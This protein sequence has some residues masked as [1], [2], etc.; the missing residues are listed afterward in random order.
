M[1]LKQFRPRLNA[2][3]FCVSV[4]PFS[5]MIQHFIHTQNSHTFATR[6]SRVPLLVFLLLVPLRYPT[7]RSIRGSPTIH[8]TPLLKTRAGEGEEEEEEEGTPDGRFLWIY[9]I[10]KLVS[11]E[12][13]IDASHRRSHLR[14][15]RKNR[16]KGAPSFR[17][18]FL[19]KDERLAPDCSTY[20]RVTYVSSS[21][22][23]TSIRRGWS[24]TWSLRTHSRFQGLVVEVIIRR[25]SYPFAKIQFAL[26]K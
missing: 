18:D 16:G 24:R 20:I 2:S 23:S 7:S 9:I 10:Y 1:R 22:V 12:I 8:P 4:N 15:G 3:F 13:K 14:L 21:F 19:S 11:R 5:E 17:E 25:T 26:L 6:Q